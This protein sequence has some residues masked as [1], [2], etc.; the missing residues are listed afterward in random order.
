MTW[1]CDGLCS[2]KV[3]CKAFERCLFHNGING[4]SIGQFCKTTNWIYL[5]YAYLF[6][7]IRALGSICELM[8]I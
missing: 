6:Y 4:I 7:I 1:T 8:L 3:C 2:R 5:M